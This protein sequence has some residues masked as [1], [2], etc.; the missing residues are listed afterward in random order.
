VQV[1]PLRDRKDDLPVL[2][3]HFMRKHGR[4]GMKARSLSSEALKIMEAYSWPG[5]IRELENEIERLLVLGSDCEVIPADLSAR[6]FRDGALAVGAS[7]GPRPAL[8]QRQDARAVEMLER[9]N[10]LPGLA[11]T[12]GNKSQLARELGIQPVEPSSSRSR[13]TGSRARPGPE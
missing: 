13:S 10:D 5:N 7:P 12:K 2:I 4:E 6:A 3:D 9:Q 11:R 1:P 8:G